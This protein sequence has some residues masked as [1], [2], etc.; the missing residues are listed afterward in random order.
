MFSV[1][2][3]SDGQC[4]DISERGI[5]RLEAMLFAMDK[6]NQDPLILPG[7]TLGMEGFDTCGVPDIA[8]HLAL[9]LSATA[10]FGNSGS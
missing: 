8:G 9:Q 6:I 5:Q 1:H 4:G 7:I 3:P 2:E 10:D